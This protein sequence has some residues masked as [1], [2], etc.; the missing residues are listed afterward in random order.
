MKMTQLINK[1]RINKCNT[2]KTGYLIEKNIVINQL[3][4]II[5]LKFI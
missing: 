2:I 1:L 3:S 4:L 5:S